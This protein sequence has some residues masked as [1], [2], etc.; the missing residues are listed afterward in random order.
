[1]SNAIEIAR[2]ALQANSYV[3]DTI[4]NNI[5]NVNTPGYSRQ[6]VALKP[7]DSLSIAVNNIRSPFA[8][9]GT[10]VNVYNVERMRNEFYDSQM[11]NVLGDYG[12]WDQQSVTYSTIESIFN[13]P[14]DVG[15]AA[16]LQAFWDAW[17][18]VQLDPSDTGARSNVVSTAEQVAQ[19]IKSTN[20]SL[21]SLRRNLNE[22]VPLK[23][24]E[25]NSLITR[26]S[27]LNKQIVKSEAE[28]SATSLKDER[29][30]LANQL[31]QL[32]GGDYYEDPRGVATIA[33]N[34]V[35]LLSE[36]EAN[37][38]DAKMTTEDGATKYSIYL[39]DSYRHVDISQGEIYGLIQSRDQV[40]PGFKSKLDEIASQLITQVNLIHKQGYDLQGNLGINFFEGTNASDIHVNDFV[41]R[42]NSLIA[43]S[44]SS[45]NVEGNSDNSVAIS[46]L[47]DKGVFDTGT[48]SINKY[49][50]NLISDLGVNSLASQNYLQTNKDIK[51]QIDNQISEV[52][53]VSIDEEM[54][55][56]IKFQNAYQAAAKYLSVI[57]QLL[58]IVVKLIP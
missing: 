33:L 36:S 42:N 22:S 55:D 44:S 48:T 54:A 35:I 5:A 3:L 46:K 31:T 39:K 47:R 12:S 38:L 32:I 50:Q 13:E 18:K 53:G 10:G 43:A 52:S 34:G 29:T 4:G 21:E 26:L 9:L 8:S 14:S 11:R 20:Q 23:V 27:N 1:M 6:R 30:R 56:M 24:D 40:V 15:I 16:N 57:Q 49:F 37:L 7:S 19:S 17:D 51:G 58:D 2:K 25:A 45:A 28:G 41:A